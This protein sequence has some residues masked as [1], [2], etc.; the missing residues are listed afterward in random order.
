MAQPNPYEEQRLHRIAANRERLQALGLL[1]HA[2]SGAA[3]AER[4][5]ARQR[6]RA[7]QPA[8]EGD[9][10]AAVAPEPTRRSRRI[11]GDAVENAGMNLDGPSSASLERCVTALG[12]CTA[13]GTGIQR[14]ALH[15][16]AQR[17]R[18]RGGKTAGMS[19]LR[20]GGC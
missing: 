7:R 8:P 10:S 9:S 3:E 2:L 11:R 13:Q 19:S 15:C 20:A 1:D 16:A 4:R 17:P 6:Q 12:G 5:A 14:K 18:G